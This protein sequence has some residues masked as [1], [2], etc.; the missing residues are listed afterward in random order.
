MDVGTRVAAVDVGTRVAADDVGT[1]VAVLD[2]GTGVA[3][4]DALALLELFINIT[5]DKVARALYH[6]RIVS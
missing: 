1:R 5:R 2:V 3:A 6:S 4:L